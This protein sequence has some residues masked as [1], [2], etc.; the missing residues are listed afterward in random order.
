MS[1][2]DYLVPYINTKGKYLAIQQ[3]AKTC[4]VSLNRQYG[5]NT[6][7]HNQDGGVTFEKGRYVI[8]Y[9]KTELYNKIRQ[10]AKKYNKDEDYIKKSIDLDQVCR[11]LLRNGKCFPSVKDTRE[12][13]GADAFRIKLGGDT[14][15]E[16]SSSTA[17]LKFTKFFL[18]KGAKLKEFLGLV[19]DNIHNTCMIKDSNFNKQEVINKLENLIDNPQPRDYKI[20]MLLPA[21]TKESLNNSSTSQQIRTAF[22]IAAKEINEVKGAKINAVYF[23]EINRLGSNELLGQYDLDTGVNDESV[24]RDINFA[25]KT[26]DMLQLSMDD[27]KVKDVTKEITILGAEQDGGASHTDGFFQFILD[28]Q[29]GGGNLKENTLAFVNNILSIVAM[30]LGKLFCLTYSA[31]TVIVSGVKQVATN[32]TAL[33]KS[34]TPH[35]RNAV[36]NLQTSVTTAVTTAKKSLSDATNSLSNRVKSLNSNATQYNL[37]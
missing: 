6:T 5:G 8:F 30:L 12:Y 3:W 19:A 20:S 7:L 25:K 31:G 29:Y 2:N 37:L 24:K 15:N 10:M 17:L 26:T 1:D 22:T 33:A 16:L 18:G 32:T 27:N 36:N 4:N 11:F 23:V 35:I 34:A 28:D 14:A 21:W 9:N 13:F